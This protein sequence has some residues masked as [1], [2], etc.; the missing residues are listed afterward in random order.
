[1]NLQQT[2][3]L[4]TLSTQ[5][6]QMHAWLHGFSTQLRSFVLHVMHLNL[7]SKGVCIFPSIVSD[8]IYR[9]SFIIL[10]LISSVLSLSAISLTPSLALLIVYSPNDLS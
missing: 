4:I 2:G 7:F 3:H 8:S 10:P 5:V 6:A 1:M 9:I